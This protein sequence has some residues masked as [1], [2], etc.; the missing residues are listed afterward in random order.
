MEP[1]TEPFNVEAVNAFTKETFGYPLLGYWTFFNKPEA[2]KLLDE[3]V[4]SSKLSLNE[5]VLTLHF[6][7]GEN[8]EHHLPPRFRTLEGSFGSNWSA[9]KMDGKR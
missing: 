8:H 6:L 2:G 5:N 3:K 1:A 4:V 7:A 9:G